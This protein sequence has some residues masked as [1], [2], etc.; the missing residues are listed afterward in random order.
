VVLGKEHGIPTIQ[1]MDYMMH[2]RKENQREDALAL[3]RRRK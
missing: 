1:L 2:K 3:L